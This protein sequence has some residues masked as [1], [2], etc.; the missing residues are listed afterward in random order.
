MTTAIVPTPTQHEND[1][2]A[3]DQLA[4]TLP[5][6][7]W[8]HAMDGSAIDPQSPDPTPKTTSWP[9]DNG[10]GGGAPDWVPANAKIHIDFLGGSPQGRAWSNGAVVAIDTLLGSDPNTENAWR[11]TQYIPEN[12]GTYGYQT[13]DGDPSSAIA[14]IGVARS[15][16]MTGATIVIKEK[17]NARAG[18]S[19]PFTGGINFLVVSADGVSVIEVDAP[20]PA[21]SVSGYSWQGSLSVAISNIM[22]D[23]ANGVMNGFA[24]T[25][26][27]TR[28]DI[29]VNGSPARTGVVDETDRPPDNPL[30]AALLNSNVEQAIQSITIHDPLPDT[31]GLSELSVVG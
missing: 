4:G 9:D 24:F 29:A 30:V 13:K 20:Y 16:L 7:P 10:G 2:L 25:V 28:L 27:P 26:V 31:T 18:T 8:C 3:E 19:Y 21:H 22:N 6:A 11:P 15:M 12:I 14:F 5:S 23:A 17:L 1:A